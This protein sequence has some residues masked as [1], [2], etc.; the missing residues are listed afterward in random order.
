MT[1]PMP[2]IPAGRPMPA[3]AAV[4]DVA[5]LPPPLPLHDRPPTAFGPS[6]SLGCT[7]LS[8]VSASTK[9]RRIAS[10]FSV[11]RF[12]CAVFATLVALS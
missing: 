7:T 10:S 8:K 11:V 2:P 12:L 1:S 9:P 6:M 4:L 3:A 5:A